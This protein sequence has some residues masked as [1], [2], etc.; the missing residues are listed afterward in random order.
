MMRDRVGP[1][2]RPSAK[3]RASKDTDKVRERRGS[4]GDPLRERNAGRARRSR[5]TPGRFFGPALA[6]A[7]VVVC[8]LA[9]QAVAGAQA[10]ALFAPERASLWRGAALASAAAQ[11]A[12]PVADTSSARI[13]APKSPARALLFSAALPGAGQLYA[14]ARTKAVA[15]LGVEAVGA[16]LWWIWTGKGNNFE[17]DF[18][19]MADTS[20]SAET[21]L[22]WRSRTTSIRNN[23]FTH[24]LPCSSYV[25]KES[26][27]YAG[28]GSFGEC[29]SSEKQQYYELLGKYE[30]F[31]VGW[32]DIQDVHT[33]N[34]V[35]YSDVDS[36]EGVR[37]AQR[38]VYEDLRNDSN[39]Y[40]KRATTV[41]GLILVNHV[42]SAIDA[43][44]TA[45]ARAQGASQAQLEERTRFLLTLYPGPQRQLG[46]EEGAR[47]RARRGA[48]R[49]PARRL[50]RRPGLLRQPPGAQPLGA[51]QGRASGRALPRRRPLLVG[52][53]RGGL[54]PALPRAAQRRAAG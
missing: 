48:A 17:D 33:N 27:Q 51:L 52:V 43:A 7:A 38:M 2:S 26:S 13:A 8:V 37:S 44:R 23:S 31:V 3:A 22:A 36:V 14:G 11:T 45:R 32:E 35:A 41:T 21:Y 24:T 50:L 42:I 53:G 1:E 19:A 18:R 40:L 28:P 39:R 12:V 49:R 29:G 47:G 4:R 6:G 34:Q 10:P 46:A 54:A 15:F 5:A 25:D 9:A 16:G 30:Q 20:W